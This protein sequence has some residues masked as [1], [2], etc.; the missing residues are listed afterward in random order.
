MPDQTIPQVLI[1]FAQALGTNLNDHRLVIPEK[2]GSGYCSGFV[3]NKYLRLLIA[4]Y[5]LNH[6]LPI[7]NPDFDEAKRTIFFKFQ[8][9]FPAKE[10]AINT[11]HFSN[12]PSVLIGTSRVN[13]DNVIAVHSNTSVINIEVDAGYLHSLFNSAE[14]SPVLQSLLQNTQPLLYE[15][16]IYPALQTIVNNILSEP[17]DKT[18]ELF[19]LKIKA[20]ELVCRLLMELKKRNEQ[21][22]YPLNSHDI[23]TIYR[24]K[25]Q[26][27]YR[28]DS[29]PLI[30]QLSAD[31]GMSPAKLKRVF[32]QV[33]GDSI[34]SYFQNVRMQEAA[35]LLRDEKLSVSE[36][37]YRLGFTNLSHFSRIFQEHM[38]MKPKQYSK[39]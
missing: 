3:F 39:L 14:K 20:E 25:A 26:I 24:V 27:L 2:S 22:I 28:L 30:A 31:A 35:R 23:Q 4:D 6:N 13:T 29:P 17:I 12:A 5:E 15:Q 7:E 21:R 38:G 10:A 34:F 19:Y 32:K 37:G 9:V 16:I 36:T 33:F 8:N 1:K 11:N 18:F